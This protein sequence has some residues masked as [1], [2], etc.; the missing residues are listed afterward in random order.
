MDAWEQYLAGLQAMDRTKPE[1]FS[2]IENNIDVD[3]YINYAVTEIY[4]G[5]TDWPGN[6]VRFWRSAKGDGKFRWVLWDLDFS[7]ALFQDF[8]SATHPT[9]HFATDGS[10]DWWPNPAVSTLHLRLLLENPTFRVRFAGRFFAAM[11]ETFHPERIDQMLKNF[12]DRIQSEMFSHKVRW[13]GRME[14]WYWEL[15]RMR[16]FAND[17]Y[18]FMKTYAREFFNIQNTIDLEVNSSN[19]EFGIFSIDEVT[20]NR[21]RFRGTM[22]AGTAV[23]LKPLPEPGYRFD[24]WEITSQQS[25]TVTLL[26]HKS[27]WKFL[28][29]GGAEPTNWFSPEYDDQNWKSGSGEFGYGDGDETTVVS[30]GPNAGNKH[31]TTWFRAN[32]AVTDTTGIKGLFGKLKYDDGVVLYLNGAEVYRANMP[33]G[34]ITAFTPASNVAPEEITHAI[35]F[36]VSY[37]KNGMN[38]L[39]AEI[40]QVSPNSSD[41]SFKLDLEGFWSGEIE[42]RISMEEVLKLESVVSARVSLKYKEDTRK[43]T[44]LVINEIASNNNSSTQP[45]REDWIELYNSGSETL[46]LNGLLIS[47]DTAYPRQHVLRA[48]RAQLQLAPGKFLVL[49]ADNR[50]MAGPLHVPF[51]LSSNGETVGIFSASGSTTEI[52]DVLNYDEQSRE[53]SWAR[54]PDGTGPLVQTS[55]VTP[56]TTNILTL[57]LPGSDSD[58]VRIYPNP[59]T[60]FIQFSESPEEIEMFSTLGQRIE[61]QHV[62]A[63]KIQISQLPSGIY[64]LKF[65]FQGKARSVRILKQ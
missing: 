5:N 12:S 27:V 46:D 34:V 61:I 2:Y 30:F 11:E 19:A 17:R 21:A 23:T 57:D 8:S 52:V 37:L 24:S 35:Q 10:Q 31:I 63:G 22:P 65:R 64:I 9:L 41:I 25:E 48:D 26:N 62:G 49:I 1:A 43:F 42:T 40:H 47:D 54:I 16:Q 59:S 4:L 20:C 14:D 29:D 15:N 56:G 58:N 39:A 55:T 13:G 7:F 32:F 38:S 51:R 6:N 44:G 50:N 53:A 18:T 3:E 33:A 28:D 60:D 45:I 36:P